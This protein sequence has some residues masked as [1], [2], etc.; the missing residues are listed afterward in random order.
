MEVNHIR[1][2]GVKLLRKRLRLEQREPR[3]LR[4][5][6]RKDTETALEG[7]N[8]QACGR[9]VRAERVSPL[10]RVERI[11]AMEDVD[12]VTPA[13]ERSG[14]AIHVGRI[15]PEAVR[16]EERGDHAELQR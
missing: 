14:K 3:R 2:N 15:A 5:Q 6:R 12:L 10:D 4:G 11:D 9:V 7:V 8:M 13:G 1:I 16:A